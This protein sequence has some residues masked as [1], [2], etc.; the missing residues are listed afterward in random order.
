MSI[1]NLEKTLPNRGSLISV[2]GL[3][4]LVGFLANSMIS[5]QVS[6]ESLRSALIENELPLTSN[7]I[8]SEIQR[9]LLQPIFTSS[10][11]ANNTFVIDWLIDG[12]HD[13]EKITRYLEKIRDRFHVFSSFLVS[14]KTKKYYHFSGVTQVISDKDAR[15]AWYFRVQDMQQNHEVNVDH[16]PEQNEALTIYINRKVFDYEG[17]YLGAIGVG[18]NLNTLNKVIDRYKEHFGRHVY[19]VDEVGKIMLR[20]HGAGITADNIH[21]ALGISAV[22][23]KILSSDNAFFEYERNNETVL[24]N[25]REIPE[26]KWYVLVEQSESNALKTIQKTLMTNLVIGFIV[27]LLTL[28]IVAYTINIFHARLEKIAMTD[29]LTGM[30][31]RTQFDFALS[32]AMRFWKRDHK[33]LSLMIIDADHFKRVN[34]TFGHLE[35]DRVLKELALLIRAELRVTDMVCRWGGEEFVVLTHNCDLNSALILAE[36]IRLSVE[37]AVLIEYENHSSVTVSVGIAEMIDGDSEDSL[38]N[39]ADDAMYIAKKEGRNC[40]RKG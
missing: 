20:S 4:L 22:A 29:K 39:R 3:I 7:N 8:Y 1:F 15:D 6:K 24:M 34:D 35:G 23:E 37:K 33:P 32:Q 40:I 9:D 30:G 13:E 18:L 28:L 25:S 2:I 16:N 36:K 5:Y 12:E 31:N 17:I 11:M 21:S 26:L 14:E 38:L 10:L 27:I 19:F